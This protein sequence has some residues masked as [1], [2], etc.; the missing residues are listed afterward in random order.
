MP[1]TTI[2]SRCVPPD[3]YPRIT[4]DQEGV[5]SVCK[6]HEARWKGW[7]ESLPDRRK[8]LERLC[9]DAKAKKKEFDVLVPL[10]GGKDSMYVLCFAVKEL[11]MKALAF[12]L[13]NGYLTPHAREN[14]DNGCRALGV[15][16]VYYCLDPKQ[17]D[18][19]YALF[20]RKTGY[21]C[22]PCMRGISMATERVADMYDVP[23]V[24]AG[25]SA[26][27]EL[28][29]SAEMFQSG[30]ADYCANVL[31]G[32]PVARSCT[33]LLHGGS[34]R[35]RVGYR[36]FW[37]GSQ[38]RIRLCAWIN[39]PDYVEWDYDT[40]YRVI[41]DE[42]GWRAPEDQMEHT[43]CAI[44]PI[45]I[46]MHNRRFPGLEVRRLTLARLIQAGQITRDEALKQL[47]EPEEE[48]PRHVLD[49]FLD[50]IGMTKEEFDN[51]IDRGPQH[52][53]YRPQP[54]AAWSALRKGKRAAFH[55]LGI[56]RS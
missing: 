10:S 19:L 13:D 7:D 37:W 25:T 23:L 41:Q 21:F 31:Q 48:C 33:R 56:R 17:Q 26:R 18:E 35:R 51:L 11:G 4:F 36:L 8:T 22:A 6:E 44:H 53:Q 50:R 1:D 30:P 40:V 12:T 55:A 5:C 32:E 27:T 52:L 34:L 46:Y 38:K 14:I 16:H 43:D 9:A 39:L 49:A 2:C 42:L 3:S 54:S 15:E 29:F 28:P 20:M 24:L 45:T 47:E